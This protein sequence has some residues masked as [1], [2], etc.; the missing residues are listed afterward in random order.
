VRWPGKRKFEPYD[1]LRLDAAYLGGQ[2]ILATPGSASFE[3]RRIRDVVPDGAVGVGAFAGIAQAIFKG[4]AVEIRYEGRVRRNRREQVQFGFDIPREH[5]GYAV[6]CGDRAAVVAHYGWFTADAK[7]L[8]LTTVLD[9]ANEI[10][11]PIKIV[12]TSELIEYAPVRIAGADFL[13]P[14]SSE[15]TIYHP[16]GSV[17]RNRLVFENCREF[18]GESRVSFE[19]R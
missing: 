4:A 8:D 7:T 1:V 12:R 14:K 10:P 5:S 13:L 11:S 15:L 6:R 9:Q 2:E 18:K 16:E 19:G 3:K 17:A